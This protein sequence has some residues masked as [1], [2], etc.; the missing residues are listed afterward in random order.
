V[1][2]RCPKR[3]KLEQFEGSRHRGRSGRKVLVV[4]TDDAWTVQCPDEI[5]RHPDEC[6]GFYFSD[7]E[8]EQN[9]LKTRL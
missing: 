2:L 9:L 3:C 6:K 1:L 7:L 8:S 4:W 5:S